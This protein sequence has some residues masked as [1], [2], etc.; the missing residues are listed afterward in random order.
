M[1]F[2]DNSR[3]SILAYSAHTNELLHLR[4]YISDSIQSMWLMCIISKTLKVLMLHVPV[5][6]F[7]VMS[8]GFHVFLG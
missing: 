7:S 1:I 5:N 8:Y 3:C 6:N 4:S 2:S